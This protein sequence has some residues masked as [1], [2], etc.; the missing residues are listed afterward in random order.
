MLYGRMAI[1]LP[2]PA[3]RLYSC[4][5]LTLQFDR[6][7]EARHSLTEPPCIHGRARMEAAQQ[8]T[9]TPQA[10]P[11]EPL[12]VTGY[13][14]GYLGHHEGGSYYP[15]HGYPKPSLRAGTS[16]SARY[17]DWHAPLERYVSYGVDQAERVVEGIERLKQRIDDFGHVQTEMQAS[18]DSQTSMMQDIFSH[19]DINPDA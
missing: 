19:F 3:P 5:C 10:H 2:N 1:R 13:G 9:T 4:E 11:Q 16:A 12:W 17:P 14:V 8:T 18:A 7:G 6:M 15:C